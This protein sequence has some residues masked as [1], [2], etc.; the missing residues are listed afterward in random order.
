MYRDLHRRIAL[1]FTAIVCGLLVISGVAYIGTDFVAS[2]SA[3]DRQLQ[4]RAQIV[5]KRVERAT[6]ISQIELSDEDD[7]E[8]IALMGQD[9][10]LLAGVA[11][12]GIGSAPPPGFSAVRAV[13]GTYRIYATRVGV[14]PAAGSTLVME[15]P[16]KIDVEDLG[17][18]AAILVAV[19]VGVSA[20]TYGLG[21][22]FA[23]RILTPVT[24]NVARLEQF[25]ADAGHELRTPLAA[26]SASLDAGLRTG[27]V[28]AGAIEA[29]TE[30]MRAGRLVDRLLELARMGRLTL[31]PEDTDISDLVHQSV[32]RNLKAAGERGL[33][34]DTAISSGVITRC[35]P[36]LVGRVIDN[37]IE[38]AVK[39]AQEETAILV[40]L[41]SSELSVVNQGEPL[42]PADK[43]DIFE[44]FVQ[45]DSSRS[46]EGNGLGLALVKRVVDLH[47]WT[48]SAWSAYGET[49]FTVRLRQ[50][51][52]VL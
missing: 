21:S 50:G 39:Y 44:A 42:P 25:T 36:A 27:D 47:G 4:R 1:S 31:E 12:P 22:L 15:Q 51:R 37:L 8:P 13:W 23:G 28:E 18:K 41:S 38:N 32:R 9:G 29:R 5:L 7:S 24:E 11:L 17:E 10:Q 46:A 30:V 43:C 33:T 2:R 52:H 26:A 16:E 35:D 48:V 49:T 14:G 6:S 3:V 19:I 40:A 34:F 45:G 20:L